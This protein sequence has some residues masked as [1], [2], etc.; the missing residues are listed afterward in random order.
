[1]VHRRIVNPALEALSGERAVYFCTLVERVEKDK[2][3]DSVSNLIFMVLKETIPYLPTELSPVD[4]TNRLFAFVQ[5][6]H[7][8]LNKILFDPQY[9][10]TPSLF[11]DVT[12][13]FVLQVLSSAL[14]QHE[15]EELKKAKALAANTYRFSW[16]EGGAT[17]RF[18]MRMRKPVKTSSYS[19]ALINSPIGSMV[20]DT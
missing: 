3:I 19:T 14:E 16:P 15:I 2:R 9:L 17:N 12:K 20:I 1:M 10:K 11:S 4:L 5:E 13:G 7:S 18:L 8:R 6:N